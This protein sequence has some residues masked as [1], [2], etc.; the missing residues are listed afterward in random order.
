[1]P[2][3]PEVET[4]RNTLKN[5][6]LHKRIKDVEVY[7]DKIIDGDTNVFVSSLINQEIIDIDRV[8]KYLVFVLDN[9]AFISHLRMEGKYFFKQEKT[10]VNKHTHVIFTFDD[11]TYLYYQDTRKFGRMQLMTHDYRSELPLSKLAK[12]PFDIQVDDLY[13]KFKKSNKGLKEI[14]LDQSVI[15]GIG[16]IYANEICFMMG[17]HPK[18]KVKY[19][20]RKKIQQLIDAS[21]VVLNHAIE[22]GGTTI[23]TFNANGIDGLFSIELNV[24]GRNNQPCKICNETIKKIVVGGRGTYFCPQCQSK[25]R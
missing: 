23:H 10:D 6:V 3:L 7:Y 18:A 20:S 14:L 11:D 17:L 21:I 16:N 19:F 25:R 13:D 22:K 9:D 5:L 8:G 15:L 12:E 1:M 24:H 2:E 4:I